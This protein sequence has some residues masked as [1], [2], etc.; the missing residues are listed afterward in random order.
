MRSDLLTFAAG[1]DLLN[2]TCALTF[3]AGDGPK[4]FSMLAYTGGKMRI[5]PLPHPVVVDLGGMDVTAKARPILKDH[6]QALIVGHTEGIEVRGRELH[7]AGVVSGAGAVA[8]EVVEASTNGFPWQASI[9]VRPVEMVLV[10]KGKAAVVNGQTFEGPFIHVR[11]ST[12]NEISFV[13]LGADD[14]TTARIAATFQESTMTFEQ[15]VSG[16][17]L[18]PA[19]LTAAQRTTLQAAY[20]AQQDPGA[21]REEDKPD[22]LA[23]E[24]ERIIAIERLCIAHPE[25]QAE[26]IRDGWDATKTELT[27]VRASRPV[28]SG[29][30]RGNQQQTA[31]VLSAAL[32]FS[33]GLG[34]EAIAE[35][36][37]ERTIDAAQAREYRGAGIHDVMHE[38]LRAAG[39]HVRPGRIT[40]DTIRAALYADEQLLRASYG[41]S[42][43]SLTGILG[44][45]ANK[46]LLASYNAVGSVVS[47]FCA[48]SDVNNFLEHNRYRLTANGVLQKVG[49]DGEL[50]HTT[51][52]EAEFSNQV[53]TYG[54][55]IALTRKM[56]INDDL[57][58]FLQIPRMMGRMAALTREELVFTLLLSNPGSFFASGNG[59]YQEG[60]GTALSITS[61]TAAE[62]LF[63]DQ[64]DADGKP[65]LLTPKVLLVPTSLKVTAQSLMTETRVNE[66]TTANSKSPANN[67]HAGKWKPIASPYLN[68]QGITGG[69]ALA[70]YLFADPR[71]VAAIELAYL[72]G[73]RTPTVESG[74]TSFATLGMQWRCYWDLGVAMQDH[75]GAVKSKGEV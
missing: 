37:D 12:L 34:E 62:K 29:I 54:R 70:W 10:A 44:D 13:A 9:G 21:T 63:L 24:Q 64:T 59:N 40:D 61:L 53:D 75:R 11:K 66:T 74:E 68:A 58:A 67:P 43:V 16:L 20:D 30:R 65:I 52:E 73:K 45:V 33:A 55:M 49:P 36:Y 5:P 56:M 2:I 18:D 23:A 60:A 17:G 7:V 22:L 27:V 46:A 41:F 32:C 3:A 25:I 19:N 4:R 50:K 42:S 48:E 39:Q 31:A 38:V 14:N 8:R 71:D 69:S 6:N 51:L 35:L 47:E 26:A 1:D 28:L 15:Y 57:G 72:R